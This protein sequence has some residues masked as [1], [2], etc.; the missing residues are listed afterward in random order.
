MPFINDQLAN[1]EEVNRRERLAKKTAA[2]TSRFTFE[3]EAVLNLLKHRVIG[4]DAVLKAMHDLLY[5]LKA[6]CMSL[7]LIL[8]SLAA[9]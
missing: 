8:P 4:Q 6:D 2:R 7:R 1:N 3:P 5:V 9:L